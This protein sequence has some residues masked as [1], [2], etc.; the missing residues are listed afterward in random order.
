MPSLSYS[1]LMPPTIFIAISLA[2]AVLALRR[3]RLGILLMLGSS[4][5]LYLSALPVVTA[6]MLQY[7][8]VPKADPSVLARAQAI[9]VL[10]AGV[11]VGNGADA[12]DAPD[13]LT[14]ERLAWAVRLYRLT[15]LPIAVTGGLLT[16]SRTALGVLMARELEQD[17]RVPVKW[18]ESASRTTFENAE[19]TAALL[20][21]GGCDTAVIVTNSWHLRRAM[22]SFKRAGINPIPYPAGPVSTRPVTLTDF[23]PSVRA[24]HDNFYYTHELL[25]LVYY[26]WRY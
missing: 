14:I 23:L 21:A 11:L 5:A 22:W 19:F 24:L 18:T 25:G 17:F 16:G 15:N 3:R 6:V 20:K 13:S 12:P 1:F 7:L 26:R 8:A 4:L 9:V 2:A 10:G